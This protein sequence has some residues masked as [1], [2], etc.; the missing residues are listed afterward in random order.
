MQE[1]VM[2]MYLAYLTQHYPQDFIVQILSRTT[3]DGT[4]YT[5]E[6]RTADG[7]VKQYVIT[8]EKLNA[9][10]FRLHPYRQRHEGHG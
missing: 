6:A 7:V 9:W 10:L 5:L 8:Q 2:E 1:A 3:I 4:H